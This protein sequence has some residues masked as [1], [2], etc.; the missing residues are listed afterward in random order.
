M[1]KSVVTRE[2]SG[3]PSLRTAWWSVSAITVVFTIAFVHR[4]G[5]GL[6]VEAMKQFAHYSRN[7]HPAQAPED[8][9]LKMQRI[10]V[11]SDGDAADYT[12]AV[13]KAWKD[14][15]WSWSIEG[16]SLH[17]YTVGGWPPRPGSTRRG[18]GFKPWKM[19]APPTM[20]AV[21]GALSGTLI[22]SIR[23]SDVSG[24]S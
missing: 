15:V 18:G 9:K 12:E 10:A 14:K 21:C 20:A 11:G 7:L 5:L 23:N 3:F 4:I 8:S 13:M 22:T 17:N 19:R 24:S 16:V 6:Y 2:Q 1:L